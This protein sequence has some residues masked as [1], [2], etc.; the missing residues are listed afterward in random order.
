MAGQEE[1]IIKLI[2]LTVVLVGLG[3]A[4]YYGYKE[5][6]KKC[7]KGLMVCLGFE[8]EPNKGPNS[9]GPNSNSPNSNGPGNA[10]S[11]NS[12]RPSESYND[13]YVECTRLFNNIDNSKKCYNPDNGSGG[14][15]WSWQNTADGKKCID[16]TKFYKIVASSSKDD[17]KNKYEYLITGGNANGFIFKNAL[18]ITKNDSGSK[19]N[20][21]FDITPL[22]SNKKILAETLAAVELNPDDTKTDCANLG[23]NEIDFKNFT[24]VLPQKKPTAEELPDPVD[25]KGDWGPWSTECKWEGTG[26]PICDV[27]FGKKYSYFQ[28]TEQPKFGG[29]A[30]VTEPQTQSCRIS[31]N[32]KTVSDEVKTTLESCEY[33]KVDSGLALCNRTCTMDPNDTYAGFYTEKNVVTNLNFDQGTASCNNDQETSKQVPCPPRELCKVD[34]TGEWVRQD[35]A[36]IVGWC[37]KDDGRTRNIVKQT[38]RFEV[39]RPGNQEG[40]PCESENGATRDVYSSY[41]CSPTIRY[42]ST[43]SCDVEG[44]LLKAPIT[45]YDHSAHCPPPP[46]GGAYGNN[47][48]PSGGGGQ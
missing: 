2:I 36:K 40:N 20:L 19:M 48:R 24:K 10:T 26:E 4:G 16:N 3:L 8:D 6:K 23:T 43:P 34:C 27:S 13:N 32:C 41:Y 14:M 9:N 45:Y 21:K 22:D 42:S 7:P 12:G 28:V 11:G 30:C 35:D 47:N 33:T 5:Y 15:R 17:H 1:L 37:S 18:D 25:C 31:T 44:G 29:K 38:E 46:E 39:T